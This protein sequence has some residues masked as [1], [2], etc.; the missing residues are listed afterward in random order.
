MGLSFIAEALLS[1]FLPNQP[2]RQLISRVG[3][4][5]GFLIVVLGR[6]QLFTENTLTDPAFA[7]RKE[8]EDARAG[9]SALGRCPQRE[10]GGNIIVCSLYCVVSCLRFADQTIPY[11]CGRFA[12]RIEFRKCICPSYFRRMVDCAD[13]LAFTGCGIREGE[14]Y[15]RDDLFNYF[16][17]LQSHHCRLD[18]YVLFGAYEIHSLGNLFHEVFLSYIARKH[19]RRCIAGSSTGARSGSGRQRVDLPYTTSVV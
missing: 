9:C 19:S 16:R 8:M 10:S 12:C 1:S 3:Y 7:A 14:H 4:S 11:G 5:I 18:Y 17:G 6:Q 15:F 13:G 2:W